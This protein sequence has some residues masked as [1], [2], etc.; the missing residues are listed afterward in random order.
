MKLSLILALFITSSAWARFSV[1][2]YNIRNFDK[3]PG[4]GQT[5]SALLGKTIKEF[6]SDVMAFIEVVNVEAFKKL[7]QVNLPTHTITH[8]EC[9]GT[10]RQKLAIIFDSSKF[11]LVKSFEDLSFSSQDGECGSLRPIFLVTL[12][13]KSTAK[14]YTFGAV[15]LKAGGSERAM[16]Q[17]W[18]QYEKLFGLVES[19]SKEN[20]I[21][22]GDFNTTG[23]NIKDQDYVKFEEFLNQKKFRTTSESLG[24]TSYWEGT[25]GNGQH[26]S[27]ILD[28]IVLK[29]SQMSEVAEVSLGSHCAELSCRPATP[30]ELGATYA[31]VSD[32]CPIKVTFK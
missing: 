17:R 18:I 19:R 2:A 23:Y 15:H 22:L 6:K 5:N 13:E 7:I 32:H 29:D 8:S 1:T 14:S 9:G 20:L 24:C 21:L 31:S 3:D 28:H 10:G 12:K 11:E 25:L 30:E 26:Q 27:S 4:A 16:K